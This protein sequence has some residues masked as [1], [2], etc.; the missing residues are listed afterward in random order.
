MLPKRTANECG[1]VG[2]S[3]QNSDW[4]VGAEF[5]MAGPI[6]LLDS[7]GNVVAFN[8]EV[9]EQIDG[10]VHSGHLDCLMEAKDW[11]ENVNVEPIALYWST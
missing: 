9:I 1:L 4:S 7:N 11:A 10:V 2:P 6:R 3:L 5:G 8:G